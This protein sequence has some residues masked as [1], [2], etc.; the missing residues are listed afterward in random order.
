MSLKTPLYQQHLDAGAKMVPFAGWEMPINY[1]SQIAEHN[2]VREAAGMFD[3]S[4][5][6]VVDV[7]GGAAKAFLQKL[8]ANDVAKIT[9]PGKA[10]YSCM[11]Q[12]DAGIIDD[13]I[14]YFLT[15][16]FYR[17]VVNAATRE[18]DLAWMQ[19]VAGEFDVSLNVRDDLAM[20]A[21]QG[22]DAV[23]LVAKLLGEPVMDLK[24]FV[25]QQMGD[26]FVART[27]YTGEDGVEIMVPNDAAAG[28]WEQ[29]VEVGVKPCGLGARDTLRLEAGM[30]LYGTDMD[31]NFTPY[32][33]ALNWTVDLKDETREFVGKSALQQT[34]NSQHFVGLV[35]LDKGVLRG[36]QKVMLGDEEIGETTSGSF[37]PTLG[38]SVALARLNKAPEKELAVDVRGRM[39][40][41]EVVK[42]PFVR[43]GKS[44]I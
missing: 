7:E 29:L 5:M 13:L 35:L 14:V 22:P 2:V 12:D 27:G 16:T 43:H 15:D 11:L 21:V 34:E 26:N 44:C 31:E 42:P 18:K 17:V 38:K 6:T 30:C 8:I 36:H 19:K 10:L 37:S 25:G 20:I 23:G 40:R 1:G 9:T 33:T 28:L 4:H 39:L 24:V 3:V 41:V 32:D